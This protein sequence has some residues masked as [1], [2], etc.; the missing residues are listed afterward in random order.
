MLSA[1]FDRVANVLT[2]IIF[3]ILFSYLIYPMVKVLSRRMPRALAVAVVYAG[4]FVAVLIAL[5]FLAPT[6]VQQANDFAQ[7]YPRPASRTP[8]RTRCSRSFP[9]R[10]AI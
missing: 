8:R 6:V 4:I 9:C 3:S 5:A 10:F 7:N 1:V 2:I